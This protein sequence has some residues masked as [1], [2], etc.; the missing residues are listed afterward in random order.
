MAAFSRAESAADEKTH[1][2]S[3]K[4]SLFYGFLDTH[5]KLTAEGNKI[6]MVLWGWNKGIVGNVMSDLG[7]NEVNGGE[8]NGVHQKMKWQHFTEMVDLSLLCFCCISQQIMGYFNT[9]GTDVLMLFGLFLEQNGKSH[10]LFAQSIYHSTDFSVLWALLLYK[11]F[12]FLPSLVSPSTS[13][14]LLWLSAL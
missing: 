10:N 8:R 9:G 3:R 7:L 4:P 1:F 13:S 2:V 6:R 11:L 14:L 5:I 12:P